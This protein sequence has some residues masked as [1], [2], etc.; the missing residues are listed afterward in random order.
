[1]LFDPSVLLREP[2]AVL[3]AAVIMVGKSLAAF[4]IVL[5]FR[6]RCAP[7]SDLGQS[8]ADRRVLFIL[9]SLG[10]LGL[11]PPDGRL[12]LAGAILSIALNPLPSP[13]WHRSRA[14]SR[15]VFGLALLERRGAERHRI[16]VASA[17]DLRSHAILVGY[18]RVGGT[19]GEALR[20]Q[21]LPFVVI[22]RD[23]LMLGNAQAAGVPTI[24][25]DASAPGVLESAGINHAP[26]V[27]AT[28]TASRRADRRVAQ[29]LKPGIDLV[30]LTDGR[31]CRNSRATQ[32]WPSNH[33]RARAGSWNARVRPA[34][35]WSAGGSRP[36]R[37]GT[38][39][40]RE[41]GRNLMSP[42][43]SEA[44]ALSLSVAAR[45]V[46]F[47]LPVA[48]LAAWLLAAHD[49]P[50]ALVRCLRA[51]VVPPVVVG[52]LL[53][54]V[55]GGATIGGWLC[56]NFG[57]QLAF[58][59]PARRSP[60]RSCRFRSWCAPSAFRS[61]LDRGLDDAARTLGAGP[62]DRFFS[63]TL[64]L[65]TPGILA[66]AVTA[67]AAGL[68]EFGA[69]ITFASNIPGETRTLPLALYTALQ[70]P[71]GD[72]MAARL[73]LISFSLGLAG[74]LVAE[75]LARRVRRM[76]GRREAGS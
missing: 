40:G 19:I 69:V 8:G 46:V 5:A 75:Y 24:V 43:E 62:V 50:D 73:A 13:A 4:V 49:L 51:A 68:G 7:R 28:P 37:C 36:R 2:L 76:I 10:A 70:T 44:L 65:I 48:I 30:V 31:A 1:M 47:N 57:V 55:F 20:S 33:G 9:A 21:G 3:A 27:V 23:H 63:I 17:V 45:S 25:G 66:G 39:R 71:D 72:S 26:V 35:S 60:P 12:R 22:E 64:P 29:Q 11:L 15:R 52:Y 16:P 56:D 42:A 41:P 67:F 18:G 14:F 58:A 32:G 38:R 54:L 61:K 74:L 59:T 53:L 34:K 6:R